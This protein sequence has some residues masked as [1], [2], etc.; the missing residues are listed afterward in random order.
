MR[1][2]DE[3]ESL[4]AVR[5]QGLRSFLELTIRQY[6]FPNVEGDESDSNWL[7]VEGSVDINGTKWTFRDP[8]LTTFEA[9]RLAD[10]LEGVSI[11]EPS[12]S[13]CFFTE[14]NLEFRYQKNRQL[15]IR[16]AL[17]SGP[18]GLHPPIRWNE[19]SFLVRVN[20]ELVTAARQLRQQL[21]R[22]PPRG[23]RSRPGR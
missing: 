16:L 3:T 4:E 20:A 2:P 1:K 23:P 6:E 7:V 12:T 9:E 17:E 5:F 21:V 8:Y 19:R 22:F 11:G 15:R 18:P 13:Y 10:W 14:P